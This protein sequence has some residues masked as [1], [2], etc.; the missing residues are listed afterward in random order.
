MQRFGNDHVF[1]VGV[2]Y[3]ELSQPILWLHSIEEGYLEQSIMPIYEHSEDE[4]YFKVIVR[5]KEG[6]S[7]G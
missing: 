1:D 7:F 6:G 5:K 4:I 2:M 3:G